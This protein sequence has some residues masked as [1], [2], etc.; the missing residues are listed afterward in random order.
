MSKLAQKEV[1]RRHD[2][3]GRHVHWEICRA[4]GIHVKPKWY[5]RQLE[6]VVEN[7]L[8]KILWYFIVQ[9]DYFITARRPDMIIND[10]E[11]HECQIINFSIPYDTRVDDKE[12]EKKTVQGTEGSMEYESDI[13]SVSSW[14]SGYTR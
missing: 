3:I 14:S 9:T 11:H 5:E 6:A 7:D 10:K 2:W 13:G 12:V 4:N 1:K 8:C